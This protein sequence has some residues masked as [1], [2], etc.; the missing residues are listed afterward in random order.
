MKKKIAISAGHN[1]DGKIACGSNGY[2]YESTANRIILKKLLKKNIKVQ[3]LQLIDCTENNAKNQDEHLYKCSSKHKLAKADYNVQL[4]FNSG[5]GGHGCEILYKS[6][7]KKQMEIMQRIL[8]NLGNIGFKNRGLK[9]RDNLYFLNK[10][11][12]SFIIEICFCDSFEDT[13]IYTR[14]KKHIVNAIYRG[15]R[16]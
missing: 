15:L 5:G 16:G 13:Q 7:N 10:L 2:F 4:H 12:N 9:V 8:K 6:A 3:A 11:E 1:P 14:Q